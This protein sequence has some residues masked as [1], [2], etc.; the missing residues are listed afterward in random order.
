[1]LEVDRVFRARFDRYL[2]RVVDGSVDASLASKRTEHLIERN[3]IEP[4]GLVIRWPSQRPCLHRAEQRRLHGVL[5]Q[6]N[7]MHA[8]SA[9]QDR[10]Q[11]PELVT[12]VMLRK[13]GRRFGLGCAHPRQPSSRISTLAPGILLIGHSLAISIACS[14]ELVSTNA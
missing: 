6:L 12:E 5:A 7:A 11:A 2:L 10:N 8:E 9:R 3:T 4:C 14:S 13:R 1:M